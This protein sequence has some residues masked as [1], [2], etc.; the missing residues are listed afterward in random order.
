MIHRHGILHSR[1]WDKKT[2]TKLWS[3]RWN[4]TQ[5]LGHQLIQNFVSCISQFDVVQV[6]PQKLTIWFHLQH[7][8]LQ[9][10]QK[11]QLSALFFG[12]S[13]FSAFVFLIHLTFVQLWVL[14]SYISSNKRRPLLVLYS[15]QFSHG[16]NCKT[17]G[18]TVQ[19]SNCL[20][21]L[22]IYYMNI[23]SSDPL[24]ND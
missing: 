3:Q 14:T 8:S 12:P 11:S 10:V 16:A 5:L 22:T 23:T 19:T 24:Q 1:N 17:L 6:L 2:F 18:Q 7:V 4:N 15:A 9:L 13:V 20:T 21:Y